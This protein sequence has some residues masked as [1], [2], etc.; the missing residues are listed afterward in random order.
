[1]EAYSMYML[2]I[3]KSFQRGHFTDIST[4][5]LKA[6]SIHSRV[7]RPA[8]DSGGDRRWARL[9]FPKIDDHQLR[10][11]AQVAVDSPVIRKN[12]FAN[13]ATAMAQAML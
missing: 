10:V 3:L 9:P 1:M 4:T 8:P 11:A 6:Y 2:A 7:L 5:L 13:S 12:R